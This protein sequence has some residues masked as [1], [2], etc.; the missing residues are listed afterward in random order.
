MS[1]IIQAVNTRFGTEFTDADRLL[2]VQ[3]I[4]DCIQNQ[5]LANQA[6][7]NTMENFKYGFD[8]VVITKWVERMDQ[9]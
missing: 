6:K 7:S 8:D 2:I 3:V 9:N 5:D 4:E 1:E